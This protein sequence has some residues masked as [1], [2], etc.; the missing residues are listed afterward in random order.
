M[1]EVAPCSSWALPKQKTYVFK[2]ASIVNP[3]NG[4]IRRA[5]VCTHEGKIHSILDNPDL[6]FTDDAQHTTIDLSGKYLCPGLIDCHVHISSVPGE[7]NLS[8]SFTQMSHPISLL[9]QPTMCREILARGFTTVRDCGGATLAL[10]EALAAG[11]FP[12]PRL[13]F[14]GHALSQS[15]GHA[16]MRS[17]HDTTSCCGGT[18]TGPGRLC[19][20]V[21]ECLRATREELRQGADFIKIMAGGGVASPTDKLESLQFTPEEIR[22][23]TTVAANS[24]T[25][26]TAHA[27][28]PFAVRTAV[29]NGVRGIEHGS[30]ID[31]ETARFMAERGVWL[32]P[33]LVTYTE[34]LEKGFL[35]P[36]LRGKND[37]VIRA[38]IQSLTIAQKAG[39]KMCYGTDLLGPLTTAQTREF[40]IRGAVLGSLETLQS[41]TVNAAEMLR[42][43]T[44]LGRIEEGFVADMIILK[45]N[46]LKNVEI[47]NDPENQLLA[48][49]KEGRV[50]VSRWS[51]LDVDCFLPPEKIE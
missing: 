16:D 32:T 42:E 6:V 1:Q 51:K 40:S 13:F 26:V 31:E 2:N 36:E 50:M 44:R 35:P 4:S 20:G 14:A 49:I 45:N 48:V 28:T 27:Y 19:D 43:E 33:T 8:K 38:A 18:V 10:K 9:R 3:K 29:E 21:P 47:L 11:A 17:S 46:P 41:A 39:V 25:Y 23:I 34:M 7:P 37:A 5:T 22:A 12:G 15:G 24:G 30:L